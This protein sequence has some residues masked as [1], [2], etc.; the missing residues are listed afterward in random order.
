MHQLRRE[1]FHD[2]LRWRVSVINGWEIDDYDALDPLYVL[3]VDK[4]NYVVVSF[5]LLPTT[6]P[7]MLND[8]FAE[9]L[10]E[11][12]RIES[13]LIWE[14]SRFAVRLGANRRFDPDIISS[15]TAELGFALNEIA[16]AAGLTH[17]V[18]VYDHGMHRMLQRC[19]FAG[20]IFGAPRD[21][22]GVI[23]HA[24]VYE[25]EPKWSL[26]ARSI[27]GRAGVQLDPI[28]VEPVRSRLS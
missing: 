24:V 6:G 14:S 19:G 2:R 16:L 15:V 3:S 25:V 17:I 18:T 1:V 13:P 10:P 26:D 8:T 5:R 4:S 28:V 27:A 21:I 20:E 11:G 9:L 23:T 12:A 7:N 22:G